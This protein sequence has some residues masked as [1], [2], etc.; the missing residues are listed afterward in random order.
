[1]PP[2]TTTGRRDRHG[3]GRSGMHRLG[4][5][6]LADHGQI[7]SLKRGGVHRCASLQV[8]GLIGPS[9]A[10]IHI[11]PE[12]LITVGDSLLAD[13]GQRYSVVLANPPFG[14]KWT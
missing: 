8:T 3:P 7:G 13:P 4:P 6:H 9:S 1:M 10:C 11:A 5:G 14:R 2:V 12:I